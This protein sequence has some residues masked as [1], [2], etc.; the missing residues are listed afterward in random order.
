M[1]LNELINKCI[2]RK[3]ICLVGAGG[4]TT[5]MYRIA[6]EASKY[7]KKVLVSTTTHIMKPDN[8]YASDME[9]IKALWDKGT[10][11]VTG[12]VDDNNPDKLV[13]MSDDL[14][15]IMKSE[16]DL[17]ILEADGAKRHPSKVPAD[18]EPVILP[19]CDFVIGVM[20]MTSLGRE[21]NECC[22]RY[23]TE[24]SWLDDEIKSSEI[25]LSETNEKMLFDENVAVAILS[26]EKGTRKNVDGREYYVVLNQCDNDEVTKRAQAILNSLKEEHGIESVCCRLR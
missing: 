18:Y 24:G 17:I 10:Y 12:K 26:S 25:E 14:Y 6:E 15:E 9:Q 20:G 4:K 19:E 1:E 11:A 3:L 13:F 23:D 21:V 8:N 7:G 5:L 16:A 2:N 22:F